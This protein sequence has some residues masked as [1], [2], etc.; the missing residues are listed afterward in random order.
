[1]QESHDHDAISCHP[2]HQPIIE[3]EQLSQI[4]LPQFRDDSPSLGERLQAGGSIQGAT[5]HA[6]R[7]IP[8]VLCDVGD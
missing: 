5:E 4:G 6:K 2:I 7:A 8:G 3:T 1:M